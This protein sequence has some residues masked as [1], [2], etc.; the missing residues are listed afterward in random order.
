MQVRAVTCKALA[1]AGSGHTILCEQFIVSDDLHSQIQ[2][3]DAVNDAC[4]QP[5]ASPPPQASADGTAAVKIDAGLDDGVPVQKRFVLASRIRA[6]GS[7]VVKAWDVVDVVQ[8][9]EPEPELGQQE[10]AKLC[11]SLSQ[12]QG[13]RPA[14]LRSVFNPLMPSPCGVLAQT[15]STSY[16]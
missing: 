9:Y 7:V 13:G 3:A 1:W 4:Q 11:H 8:Q 15:I 12:R 14:E 2:D 6:S 5:P 16:P 10:G